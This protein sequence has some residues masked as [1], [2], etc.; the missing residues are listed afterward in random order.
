MKTR[1]NNILNIL[2]KNSNLR[3]ARFKINK[4]YSKNISLRPNLLIFNPNSNCNLLIDVAITSNS[5]NNLELG[6]KIKIEKYMQLINEHKLIYKKDLK[7]IT[8]IFSSLGSYHPENYI[9]YK[10][11][12][13]PFN[14]FRVL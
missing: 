6:H 13:I 3:G 12:N 5:Q 9:L 1:H 8:A 7:I 14:P 11:L 10:E 2:I 4:N